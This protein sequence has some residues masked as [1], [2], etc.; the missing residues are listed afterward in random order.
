MTTEIAAD[1]LAIAANPLAGYIDEAEMSRIRQ[2]PVRMLRIERQR[3]EGPPFLKD[4]H[5]IYYSI[6]GFRDWLKSRERLPVRR[7]P[8]R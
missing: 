4:G 2:R 6:D 1:P 7:L 3:S 8:Q 5:R